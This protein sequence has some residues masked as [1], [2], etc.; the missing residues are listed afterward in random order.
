MSKQAVDYYVGLD[1]SQSIT[2][3]CVLD[4]EGKIIHEGSANSRPNDIYGWL[5]NRLLS[6]GNKVFDDPIIRVGLEAGSI[7][8]WLHAGLCQNG[9]D[10]VC[11]ETFQAHRF[12]ATFRNKTD[13]NDARGLAQLLRMGGEDF[14]R[15]VR[16]KSKGAQ[17]TRS[18]LSMR[19]HLVKLK[20][21]MENHV[22]GILKPYGGI[23]TRT[24]CKPRTFRERM[25]QV[26]RELE[27]S[28]VHLMSIVAPTLQ[29]HEDLVR[30][31]DALTR[32]VEELAQAI[33]MVKRFMAIPGVGP[34]TALSF[35]CAVDH[36]ERFSKST[37]VAAYFGLTPRQFQSGTTDYMA[38]ISKRGD[39]AV[40]RALVVAATVML[41]N[42]TSWCSLKAWG[43][44]LAARVGISKAR[45]AVARKLAI[46]MHRMW[47][48]NDRWRPVPISIE[49]RQNLSSRINKTES[50]NGVYTL[51]EDCVIDEYGEIIA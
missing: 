27:Q 31:I 26:T 39:G 9:L 47:L 44:R 24:H 50:S 33:P 1:V 4:T 20:V 36:P 18:L 35:Y 6:D 8:S 38:G 30:R 10:V 21:S 48:N 11:M 16:I 23:V 22:S 43:M 46:I 25:L 34:I 14:L 37:D 32:R 42:T 3:I 40:R 13:K 17:E 41:T 51:L 19:N 29:L 45:V 12:L 7:S 5:N 2:T 49:E 15:V 28:D